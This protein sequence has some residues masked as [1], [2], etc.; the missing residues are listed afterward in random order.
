MKFFLFHSSRI[1]YECV[2]L[3]IFFF[4]FLKFLPG[5]EQCLTIQTQIKSKTLPFNLL[6]RNFDE[7]VHGRNAFNRGICKTKTI[8]LH[9]DTVRLAATTAVVKH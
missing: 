7:I 9:V 1:V 8:S 6:T 2:E 5:G 3:L 4:L